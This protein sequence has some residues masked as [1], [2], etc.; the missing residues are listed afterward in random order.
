MYS[1]EFVKYLLKYKNDSFK[2][3]KKEE[4]K[5]CFFNLDGLKK[6][7]VTVPVIAK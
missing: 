4:T 1:E 3:A 5:K 6:K 2:S 7:Y